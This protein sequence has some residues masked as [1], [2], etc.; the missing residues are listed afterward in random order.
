MNSKSSR[1]QRKP[2]TNKV[3]IVWEPVSAGDGSIYANDGTI[4]DPVR[5][6]DVNGGTLT[7]TNIDN[8]NM[9]QQTNNS[10]FFTASN[11][12]FLNSLQPGAGFACLLP[13]ESI[14]GAIGNFGSGEQAVLQY[15]DSTNGV[16][17]SLLAQKT[18]VA[19]ISADTPGAVT[20]SIV[21][22]SQFVNTFGPNG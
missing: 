3:R 1:N 19:L 9:G 2:R 22:D 10:C 4:T 13:T 8:I 5:T 7:F 21:V 18:N 16:K 14:F 17:N 15:D 11:S 20:E 12:N 6:I